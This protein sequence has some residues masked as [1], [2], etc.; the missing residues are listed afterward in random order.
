MSALAVAC[1]GGSDGCARVLLEAG[2]SM[3]SK[4]GVGYTPLMHACKF[5]HVTVLK[6][7]FEYMSGDDLN[8]KDNWNAT[9]LIHAVE[10][11]QIEAVVA[12]LTANESARGVERCRVNEVLVSKKNPMDRKTALDVCLGEGEENKG[13]KGEQLA[14]QA[15]LQRFGGQT[16]EELEGGKEHADTKADAL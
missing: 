16:I 9:P 7:L 3:Q 15:C 10:Q 4:D 1:Q 2:A 8:E 6:V 12:L 11:N 13:G 14:M 5:G